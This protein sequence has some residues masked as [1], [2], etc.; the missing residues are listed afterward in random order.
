MQIVEIVKPGKQAIAEAQGV[1]REISTIF[2]NKEVNKGDW[3]TVHVGYALDIIDMVT[4]EEIFYVMGLRSEPPVRE[5]K[6]KGE[7]R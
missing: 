3:V 7:A 2:L 6:G 5:P 4:A 1:K